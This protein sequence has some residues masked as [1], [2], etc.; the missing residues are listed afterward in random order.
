MVSS[1]CSLASGIYGSANRSITLWGLVVCYSFFQK[2][3]LQLGYAL[4]TEILNHAIG[5]I[6]L[7]VCSVKRA[8][9]P[10]VVHLELMGKR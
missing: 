9:H 8:D 3:F 4:K 2:E 5:D 10:D 1:W 6:G 7:D